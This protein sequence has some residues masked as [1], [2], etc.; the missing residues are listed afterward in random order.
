WASVFSR[1]AQTRK[2]V[3]I[4]ASPLRL[5]LNE[6]LA[7]QAKNAGVKF[8]I[9][10]DAHAPDQLGNLRYGIAIARRAWLTKADV[11]N[12]MKANDFIS[13]LHS[14]RKRL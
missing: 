5:D 10:T 6:L 13:T 1:A 12:T 8:L 2:F 4:N 9:D 7:R 3:E 14:H 11:A